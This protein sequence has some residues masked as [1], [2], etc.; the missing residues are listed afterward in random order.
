MGMFDKRRF[1][2][3]LVF[4]QNFDERNPRTYQDVD[5][6]KTTARDLFCRFDLGLDVMELIGHSIA[7]HGSDRSVSEAVMMNDDRWSWSCDLLTLSSYLDQPCVETIRRV[8][9]Y[10]E[11]LSRHNSSPYLY[12]V[13]GLGELPQGFARL[14]T[15]NNLKNSCRVSAQSSLSSI[16]FDL[17]AVWC[18]L[19]M[20]WGRALWRTIS[21]IIHYQGFSVN[22]LIV[23]ANLEN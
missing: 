11:S 21:N 6:T 16:L 19:A 5:P 8:R 2:K 7:L 22:C 4:A 13:Y 18:L 20:A 14:Y 3:L 12:P 1:R 23:G 9:L 15:H 10:S 17:H